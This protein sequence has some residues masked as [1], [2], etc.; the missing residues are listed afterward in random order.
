MNSLLSIVLRTKN[1]EFW[2]G[3]FM[4]AIKNQICSF[5]IEVVLV[6]N[7]ST[8]CTVARAISLFER[9]KLVSIDR[10]IPGA[11]LN[12]G[13]EVAEGDYIVC[14]SA[15][16]IPADQYWLTELIAPLGD[17]EIAAV[18]GRQIPLLTSDPKDK[19]DLWL[20]FGLDDKIQLRDPFLH[21]ANAAYRRADLL[22]FPFCEEMTNIEDRHWAY[23]ELQR[24]RKIFYASNSVVYHDHGIHQSGNRERLNG[25]INMMDELHQNVN[26]L[27]DYY[28]ENGGVVSPSKCLIIAISDR[29]GDEDLRMLT[30]NTQEIIA[31]FKGWTIY[32]MPKLVEQVLPAQNLGFK[33]LDFRIN[34]VDNESNPLVVDISKAVQTLTARTEYYDYIATFDIRRW[35]PSSD[36]LE[37]ALSVIQTD[38]SDAVIGAIHKPKPVFSS[39][40]GKS[41]QMEYAGWLNWL[42]GFDTTNVPVLD[43]SVFV[44]A[45]MDVFRKGNPLRNNFSTVEFSDI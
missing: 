26:Q 12:R 39:A 19:R 36:F 9:I 10:Y 22:K 16:C 35:V 28:G 33:I 17:P 41:Y 40:N 2:I 7:G 3:R 13:L 29:Y 34:S 23:N 45:K 6:D 37:R 43:P 21:N 24:G 30:R 8:D 4:E 1:E 18:Y 20:T 32:V 25:V 14:I 31:R 11:A 42:E 27:K 5:D 38:N 44:L 15:H